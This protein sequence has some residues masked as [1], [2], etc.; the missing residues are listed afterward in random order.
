[1]DIMFPCIM[2]YGGKQG[3]FAAENRKES[4]LR[5]PGVSLSWS[6][7]EKKRNR[8]EEERL[9]VDGYHFSEH[10]MGRCS[11]WSILRMVHIS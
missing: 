7:L 2:V 8:I 10:K 1:M 6:N 11:T 3:T 5:Q 9:G 4:P